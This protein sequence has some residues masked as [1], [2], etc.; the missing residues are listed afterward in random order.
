MPHVDWDLSTHFPGPRRSPL[1]VLKH[2]GVWY[3]D[4]P[5]LLRGEVLSRIPDSSKQNE[6]RNSP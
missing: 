2:F 1:S 3:K 5:L 6:G 4:C